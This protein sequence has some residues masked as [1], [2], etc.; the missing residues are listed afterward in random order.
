MNDMELGTER[1]N[2]G[3]RFIWWG[4]KNSWHRPI[5]YT[6]CILGTPDLREFGIGPISYVW[7]KNR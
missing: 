7:I 2:G 5:W 1:S 6:P 4:W 3:S